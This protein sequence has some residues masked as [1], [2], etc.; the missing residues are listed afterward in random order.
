MAIRWGNGTWSDVN[1]E[2]LFN[3]PAIATGG[4]TIADNVRNFNL[5]SILS[6]ATLLHDRDNSQAWR[7]WHH[8]SN[9]AYRPDRHDLVV[10]DPNGRVQAVINGQGVVLNDSLVRDEINEGKLYKIST[11]GLEDYGYYLAY[12]DEALEN[13][14]LRAFREWICR[15]AHDYKLTLV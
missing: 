1:I 4:K 5:E 12:P 11:I 9:V 7:D 3:C 10:V 14:S 13:P 6:D 2:L 8:V 15:A